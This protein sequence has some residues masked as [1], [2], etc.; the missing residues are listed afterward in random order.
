MIVKSTSFAA[1]MLAAGA[2]AAPAKAA[3]AT[4]LGGVK[5]GAASNVDQ[6]AY[7]R[8]RRSGGERHCRVVRTY[9]RYAPAYAY[10]EDDGPDYRYGR[11]YGY[12]GY[13]PSIGFSIGGARRYRD[14]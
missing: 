6:A 3:P 14:W 8:C 2:L 11:S 13:G 1:I 10:D 5:E 9:R 12:Y 7:R 4:A